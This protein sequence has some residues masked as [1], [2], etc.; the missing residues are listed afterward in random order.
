M[1]V[2]NAFMLFLDSDITEKFV[3]CTNKKTKIVYSSWNSSK[4]IW[5]PTNKT[6]MYALIGLLIS[7]GALKARREP[8]AML[9][10]TDSQFQRK[11][12]T[13][14]SARNRFSEILSYIRFTDVTT[15]EERRKEDK[16]CAF[17]DIFTTFT[18]P[19]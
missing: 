19:C 16:S 4:S 7:M 2:S 17:S 12:F 18:Q 5:I 15:R 6:E 1:S 9:W 11:I 13:V 8:L 3:D 14:S 10:T